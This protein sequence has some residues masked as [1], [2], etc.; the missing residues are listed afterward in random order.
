MLK[1]IMLSIILF[2]STYY[3]RNYSH[4][5]R[6]FNYNPCKLANEHKEN[7]IQLQTATLN[8]YEMLSTEKDFPNCSHKNEKYLMVGISL[9][10]WRCIMSWEAE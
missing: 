5:N 1:S 9:N 3:S 2:K 8:R 10:W 7:Y 6:P 4:K